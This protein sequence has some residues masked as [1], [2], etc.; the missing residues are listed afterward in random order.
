MD[1]F[2]SKSTTAIA[3][4]LL[5][6]TL[7]YQKNQVTYRG[8]IVET[9]AYLGLQDKASHAAN[10]HV[11]KRTQALY[12]S[13]GGRIYIYTM[14]GLYLLNITTQKAAPECVLIRGLEPVAPLAE[15]KKNRP[16]QQGSALTNGPGK[17]CRAI[18][19][20]TLA[21]NGQFI[22]TA[23]IDI[24]FANRKQPRTIAT[25]ARIGVPDKGDWT[26]APLRYYVVGNPYVSK[27][28]KKT[29]D[30]QTKGWD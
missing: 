29:I 8:L 20:A 19:L 4:A 21:Y 28:S 17:L 12:Q 1:F 22:G 24:S 14:R 30:F 15:I 11:T 13:G 10:G 6:T 5:G 27:I 9:E 26:T 16:G 7:T 3:K 25:T 23:P 18:D 2:E